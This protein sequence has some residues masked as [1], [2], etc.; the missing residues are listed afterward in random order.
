MTAQQTLQIACQVAQAL[1]PHLHTCC[2][3][4]NQQQEE[5]TDF[6]ALDASSENE[7][8]ACEEAKNEEGPDELVENLVPD[9]HHSHPISQVHR[10]TSTSLYLESHV[11]CSVT[12]RHRAFHLTPQRTGVPSAPIIIRNGDP[13]AEHNESCG[14]FGQV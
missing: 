13:Q 1:G 7:V 6:E 5:G 12:G 2:F 9:L 8:L 14:F 10:S 3:A 11:S 4:L